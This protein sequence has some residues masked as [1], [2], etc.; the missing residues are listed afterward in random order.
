MIITTPAPLYG[1]LEALPRWG[2]D[3]CLWA[4][5]GVSGMRCAGPGGAGTD[6]DSM[7]RY[8]ATSTCRP[9]RGLRRGLAIGVGDETCE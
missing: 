7:R 5:G 6:D 2:G 1:L 9:S 3:G 4:R 8:I